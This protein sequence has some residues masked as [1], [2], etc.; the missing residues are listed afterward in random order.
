MSVLT[1]L[2]FFFFFFAIDDIAI[3][4]SDDAAPVVLAR[5]GFPEK[6]R[7]W[8]CGAGSTTLSRERFGSDRPADGSA[9]DLK[10]PP[11]VDTRQTMEDIDDTA[12]CVMRRLDFLTGDDASLSGVVFGFNL[13]FKNSR[14]ARCGKKLW[15]A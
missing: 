5:D 14:I 3:F 1:P 6:I 7:D 12:D 10:A 8:W 9:T 4:V 2:P 11:N 13:F 15:T